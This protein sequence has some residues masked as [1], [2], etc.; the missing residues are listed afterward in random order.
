MVT[1]LSN[2]TPVILFGGLV[3]FAIIL[4]GIAMDESAKNRKQQQ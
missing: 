1:I 2:L 4:G 3:I